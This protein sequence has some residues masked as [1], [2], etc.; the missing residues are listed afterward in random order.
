MLLSGILQLSMIDYDGRTNLGYAGIF[1]IGHPRVQNAIPSDNL[2]LLDRMDRIC[3]PGL[4]AGRRGP[5][6]DSLV[7]AGLRSVLRY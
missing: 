5:P 4:P 6:D 7:N 3:S 1:S 2:H